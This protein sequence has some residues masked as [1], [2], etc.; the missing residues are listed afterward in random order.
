MA[1]ISLKGS[2][3]YSILL[4]KLDEKADGVIKRAIYRGADQ[5]IDA[6][7]AEIDKLPV[8]DSR[9]LEEGEQYDVLTKTQKE[10]LKKAFGTSHMENEKGEWNTKI[11]VEGYVNKRPTKRYPKGLPIPMLARSIE[12]GT[13]VRKKY[14]FV[15]N[16]V[17]AIRK[18]AVATMGESVDEDCKKIMKK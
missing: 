13:S 14:P 16:A 17:N 2:E 8:E 7:K 1:K 11:G 4:Q 3:E 18:R 9:F 6:I 5:V 15:R 12:S 10:A